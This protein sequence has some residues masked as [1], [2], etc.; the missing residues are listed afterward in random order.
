MPR[1]SVANRGCGGQSASGPN[2]I[3]WIAEGVSATLTVG[4][5]IWPESVGSSVAGSSSPVSIVTGDGSLPIL[6]P[7]A[8]G[9]SVVVCV[10][11]AAAAF[12]PVKSRE[13]SSADGR[14]KVSMSHAE[15][16]CG[17]RT[18]MGLATY[19]LRRNRPAF[20]RPGCKNSPPA[21]GRL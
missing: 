3:G 6:S 16:G 20:C 7:T 17:E 21:A 18:E 4:T 19:P 14:W 9:V 10:S 1:C 5:E 2:K 15:N 12:E 13:S 11:S 8:S